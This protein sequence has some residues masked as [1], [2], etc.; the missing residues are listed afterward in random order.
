MSLK[1]L[2]LAAATLAALASPA[3]AIDC[4]KA[5]S[6]IE[7]GICGD[8]GLKAADAALGQAYGQIVKAAAGDAE[9]HAMLVASQKR[10]LAARDE[11]FADP[12]DEHWTD[13]TPWRGRLLDAIRSRTNALARRSTTDPKQFDLIERAQ[14]QRQFAARLSGG[15][16]AGFETRCDFFPDTPASWAD[17]YECYSTRYYRNADRVCSVGED[18]ATYRQYQTRSIGRLVDGKLTPVATCDVDGDSDS[19]CPDASNDS[20]TKARWN[21][22]PKVD[23][24][25]PSTL[26]PDLSRLDADAAGSMVEGEP[27]GTKDDEPWL[28]ACLTDSSYPSADPTSDGSRK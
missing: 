9:I 11:T 22:Q 16:F 5:S 14:A 25:G 26:P 13:D 12:K 2:L 1:S 20:D 8:K 27:A 24:A 4:S 3:H 10:W 15:S 7:H 18:W 28:H 23:D 21:L 17:H 6:A 19:T